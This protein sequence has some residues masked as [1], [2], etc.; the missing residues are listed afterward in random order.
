MAENG[1]LLAENEVMPFAVPA[2]AVV[3]MISGG[4]INA[5]PFSGEHISG[6]LVHAGK[7]V[8]VFLDPQAGFGHPG[9]DLLVLLE[10][11]GELLALPVR[12]IAGFTG[13]CEL[14]GSGEAIAGLFSGTVRM[15]ERIIAAVRVED[16]YKRA[17][18][19]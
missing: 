9:S 7:A 16:L 11:G 10:Q 18:F 5:L 14:E 4:E 2:E 3:E 13:P 8:P 15:G 12:K 17:G 6:I 1:W 19:I